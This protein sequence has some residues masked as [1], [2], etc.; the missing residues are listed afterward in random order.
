LIGPGVESYSYPWTN[1]ITVRDADLSFP[2]ITRSTALRSAN[3][4]TWNRRPTVGDRIVSYVGPS[5]QVTPDAIARYEGQGCW[6]ADEKKD[7]A[8]A[9]AKTNES[10]VI[11]SLVSR[12][13]KAFTPDETSGLLGLPTPIPNTTFVAELEAK[14]PAATARYK[15]L[16]YRRLHLFDVICLLGED[17]RP[18]KRRNRS[19][20]V[21]HERRALLELAVTKFTDPAIAKRLPI[22]RQ[23]KAGFE[24]FYRHVMADGGEGLV[25]KKVGSLYQPF[26]SD[27]KVSEWHRCKP[28]RF[29]DYVVL[30]IGKS[31]SGQDNFQVGLYVKG[32]LKRICTIKNPPVNLDLPSLV[33]KVIECKGG[34]IFPSG[35]L[36]HGHFERVRDDKLPEHCTLESTL[37]IAA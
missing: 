30:S 10:G 13:G 18:D 32:T 17:L 34:E 3:T 33:G 8:W 19:G 25:F 20:T 2:K 21:I 36:R 1:Q 11:T 22:V 31:P 16:G 26:N 29:V 4:V 15:S 23:V 28:Y 5:I 7:G 6:F 37:A 14:S 35:A 27:G 9:E 12:T 24:L